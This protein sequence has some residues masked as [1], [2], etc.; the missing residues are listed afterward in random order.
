[1]FSF[2]LSAFETLPVDHERGVYAAPPGLGISLGTVFYKDSA[3]KKLPAR[4]ID[5][6]RLADQSFFHEHSPTQG[7][8][9]A[10]TELT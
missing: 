6:Q 1:L 10:P 3:F 4:N 8:V 2:Q 5:I 9:P 7:R